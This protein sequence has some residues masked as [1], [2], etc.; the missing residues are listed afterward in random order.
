MHE[1]VEEEPKDGFHQ[2]TSTKKTSFFSVSNY[3]YA[4]AHV[5]LVTSEKSTRQISAGVRSYV[6]A[7]AYV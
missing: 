1:V 4:H 3:A 6:S 2:S 7:Y 5:E